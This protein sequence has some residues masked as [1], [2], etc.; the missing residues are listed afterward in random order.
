MEKCKIPKV[1]VNKFDE[2]GVEKTI[3][4]VTEIIENFQPSQTIIVEIDSYGGQVFGLFRLI[5]F[6]N[7]ISNPIATYCSSKAMSAGAILLS[8]IASPGLRFASPLAQ[9]MIHEI[10]GFGGFGDVKEIECSSDYMKKLNKQVMMIL[11]QSMGLKKVSD[12]RKLIRSKTDGNELY[13]NAK[14]SLAL[15]I[16]DEIGYITLIHNTGYNIQLSTKGRIAEEK[17]MVKREE[18]RSN[19]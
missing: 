18:K 4:D 1:V 8:S 5:E 17:L 7:S 12:V 14:D 6:F 3:N 13:L 9:I 16:I 10:Q 15:N 11:A 19:K 2:V